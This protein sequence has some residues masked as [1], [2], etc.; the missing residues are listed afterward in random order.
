MATDSVTQ[1]V[2]SLSTFL[3][4]GDAHI[5]IQGLSGNAAIKIALYASDCRRGGFKSVARVG[6][7]KFNLESA[8]SEKFDF[9]RPSH[10]CLSMSL[11]FNNMTTKQLLLLVTYR[12]FGR[13]AAVELCRL[14]GVLSICLIVNQIALVLGVIAQ[15][16]LNS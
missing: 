15:L 13:S 12:Y 2:P 9:K 16:N 3:G 7:T 11:Q 4:A 8:Y 10:G 1:F 6:D 5:A 14:A